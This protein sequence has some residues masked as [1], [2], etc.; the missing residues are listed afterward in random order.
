M[1]KYLVYLL[2]P[3]ALAACTDSD[4]GAMEGDTPKDKYAD[5]QITGSISPIHTTARV[6]DGEMETKFQEN[7]MM[8]IGWKHSSGGTYSGYAYKYGSDEKF[9]PN[10]GDASA[11]WTGLDGENDNVDVYAWYSKGIDNNSTIPVGT[12]ISVSEDQSTEAEYTSN[13]YLAAHASY[14]K[15]TTTSLQFGFSHLMARLKLSIDFNDKG[16]STSDMINTKVTTQL[17]TSAT[18]QE[19]ATGTNKYLELVS[20]TDSKA[21]TMLAQG[22]AGS[23]HLDCTCLL[24]PQTLTT[25]SAIITITLG[26]GKEYTCTLS[27]DLVL[28]AGEEAKLSIDITVEGTSVYEPVVTVIP[29]TDLCSYSGNRLITGNSNKTVSIYDKQADGSWGTPA[30]VYESL[31]STKPLQLTGSYYIRVV[32]LYKDYAGL[33][34]SVNTEPHS[35]ANDI[36]Y[37]CKR[38]KV[39]GKWYV[40][41][42]LEN[43]PCYSLVLNNDFFLYGPDGGNSTAIPISES[44]ELLTDYKKDLSG[45]SGFKLCLAENN[46]FCTGNYLGRIRL[47]TDNK[48]T[49]DPIKTFDTFRCFTDGKRLIGQKDNV[50][51]FIYNINTGKNDIME[52]PIK[53]SAGRPVVIYEDY[54]L[55]GGVGSLVLYYF[56]GTK[57]IRLGESNDGNSFLKILQK[58]VPSDQIKNLQSLDGGN[59]MMKGTKVSIVSKNITYFV[60][61]IDQIV[62]QYLAD[63]PLK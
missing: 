24:P 40:N 57:W 12:T 35:A 5:Y 43:T 59:L 2:L 60:E 32:D 58:Y 30:L 9:A 21:I 3:M 47:G 63:N 42:K 41:K 34:T 45:I 22:A 10:D 4:D 27:K 28:K 50:N 62:K 14:I 20:P 26:N 6:V 38:D 36:A 37:F 31:E 51:I 25:H 1:K 17:Y 49:V 33:A 44:G 7:D 56:E 16:I 52:N 29:Q 53:V 48:P 13:I 39:T 55:A 23:Y 61:N 11:L 19:N 8:L 54:A 46:V 18:L 15:G